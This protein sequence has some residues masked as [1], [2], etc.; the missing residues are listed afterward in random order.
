MTQAQR[1]LRSLG[2][3]LLL[4]MLFSWPLPRHLFD[5]IPASSQNVE[6]GQRRE[7][8]PG[9]HLQLLYHFDLLRGMLAGRTPWFH[10]VY[11]FNTGRDE[12]RLLPTAYYAPFS[13]LY[14]AFAGIAGQ[15]FAWN[16][17]GFV[18]LW[19]T[20][21]LTWWLVR[22]FVRSEPVAALAALPAILLPYRWVNLLGGS[23]TGFAM[24]WVPAVWIG[25]DLAVRDERPAGGVL[26]GAALLF[27]C[28]AD[29]QTL[30]F[31]ALAAPL[32]ILLA[33]I[34]SWPA[35]WRDPERRRAILRALR[36]I[37]VFLLLIVLYRWMRHSHLVAADLAGRRRLA[38]AANFSPAPKGLWQWAAS[39]LESHVYLGWV[40][41]LV[42]AAGLA[43]LGRRDLR[44]TPE[45]RR[46]AAVFLILVAAMSAIV[47]LALGV[48]GPLAGRVLVAVR[49][50]I[51]PYALLR[52]TAKIYC[53]VPSILAVA[54][55]LAMTLADR[56]RAPRLRALLLGGLAAALVFEMRAQVRPTLC[57]L[58]ERQDAYAAVAEDARAAGALPRALALPLWPGQDAYSSIYEFYAQRHG[59]RMVNGYS[60]V[61]RRAYI[62]DVFERWR[63]FNQGWLPDNELDDL[64]RRGIG[65]ILLHENL[66]PEQVSPFPV[67]ATLARLRNHPRLDFLAHAQTVWAF[68]IR[69]G[70]RAADSAAPVLP[71]CG[72]WFPARRWELEDCAATPD[73]T[74]PFPDASAGRALVLTQPGARGETPPAMASPAA[75]L[76][77]MLRV[78]GRG[79][80]Q[81]STLAD[82]SV[83]DT[84]PLAVDADAWTWQEIPAPLDRFAP[85]ALRLEQADG[86]VEADMVLLAAGSW[87]APAPGDPV[88]IPAPCFFH[89][90]YTDPGRNRVMLRT[91]TDPRAAILYGPKLP[92]PPGRY[93]AKFVFSSPAPPDTGLGRLYVEGLDGT[94][95]VPVRAGPQPARIEWTQESNLPVN[96]VFVY[97][98]RA[99]LA[100][101]SI[102]IER[103][104]PPS[105]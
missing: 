81:A 27:L 84:R 58:N 76:R 18:S 26:A 30:F 83:I 20:Y 23:P 49:V 67:L 75:K 101:E 87:T 70:P 42:L 73:L 56:G 24:L 79:T 1:L 50:L 3:S 36:P 77:W 39:G 62:R 105:P 45:G 40:L 28:W 100:I 11:E 96:L 91:A 92:L 95:A 8:I 4:W 64:W 72:T 7:M 38:E 54:S 29:I 47:V 16:L 93:A 69:P 98:R 46:T 14:A 82:S 22:R 94:N 74:E 2:V 6:E 89:G 44:D 63:G 52:Q 103:L 66:F 48:Q 13:L 34:P 15:A 71:E 33:L 97:L 43:G 68:R 60:P 51:P 53:L 99:D 41:P 65:Y 85:L 80:I 12:E 78:R 59:V 86:R 90:G 102:V 35:G 57:G 17:V 104:A 25:L 5:A 37:A 55:A 9:D 10:N 32:W 31:C 19:L 88:E 61:V 21:W